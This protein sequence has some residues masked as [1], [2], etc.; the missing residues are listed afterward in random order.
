MFC[1]PPS[2]GNSVEIIE[3]EKQ[4][5]GRFALYI[6][7]GKSRTLMNHYNTM[8]AA[9]QAA[10]RVAS[11]KNTADKTNQTSV[12]SKKKPAQVWLGRD[13]KGLDY[14]Q[15]LVEKSRRSASRKD[16]VWV[17]EAIEKTQEKFK[18]VGYK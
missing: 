16:L 4:N 10:E 15:A 18:V 11:N 7:H 8:Q 5:K 1:R 9:R 2:H 17:V 13:K 6:V 14:N 3:D 12:S